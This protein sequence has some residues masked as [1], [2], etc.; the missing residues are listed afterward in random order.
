MN[1]HSVKRPRVAF[2]CPACAR[3]YGD[4]LYRDMRTGLC[5]EC[6]LYVTL[7]RL[8]RDDRMSDAERGLLVFHLV[9]VGGYTLAE[10]GVLL[11]LPYWT[12]RRALRDE[13]ARRERERV[14]CELPA[15]PV[16][17]HPTGRSRGRHPGGVAGA[18]GGPLGT[19]RDPARGR[20]AAAR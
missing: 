15:Q 3:D 6:L 4:P 1:G 8:R 16:E 12:A 19:V 10:C 9:T 18:F 11:R 7:G 14:A 13:A 5:A 20:A 2:R 17:A